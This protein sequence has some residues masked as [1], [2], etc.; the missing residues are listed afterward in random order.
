MPEIFT[1]PDVSGSSKQES[2]V[3]LD[4]EEQPVLLGDCAKASP[5]L[6]L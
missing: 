6:M 3:F 1:L 4:R 5:K 2:A